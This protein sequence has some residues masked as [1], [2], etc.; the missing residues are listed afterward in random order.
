[1]I[2][3]IE[4][5]SKMKI[6]RAERKTE[7]RTSDTREKGIS[8]LILVIFSA[9]LVA[10]C[11]MSS[12]LYR[13]NPWIDANS[14][15][16]AAKKMADGQVM[17]RD[18]FD[19]KGPILY[20]LH[21]FAVRLFSNPAV[22][23]YFIETAGCIGLGAAFDRILAL[24]EIRRP[25]HRVFYTIMLL[26]VTYT[27]NTFLTGDTTEEL[28]L[29]FL[30]YGLYC[31][32]KTVHDDKPLS[33]RRGILIGCCCGWIFWMK[34]TLLGF[35]VCFALYYVFHCLYRKQ[36]RELG[37]CVLSVL[38]GFLAVTAVVFPYF[39]IHRALSDLLEVYFYDNIFFYS[40]SSN[41][42]AVSD[43]IDLIEDYV[44]HAAVS[45]LLTVVGLVYFA[46]RKEKFAVL[47]TTL[48][49]ACILLLSGHN[50]LYYMHPL[51]MFAVLGIVPL[52]RMDKKHLYPAILAVVAMIFTIGRANTN[53]KE[54][55]SWIYKFEPWIARKDQP[56][57]L[58]YHCMEDEFYTAYNIV[59]EEK[60]YTLLNLPVPEM[61][62]EQDR[63]VAEKR[64]DFIITAKDMSID[65]Y[66]QVAMT[67][68][69][70]ELNYYLYS[71]IQ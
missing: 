41:A 52:S 23:L 50:W 47:F 6:S 53:L 68:D 64:S 30:C 15:L 14:Y 25:L 45:V 21:Y 57:L 36:Y 18:I 29:P 8:I 19:H 71:R 58:L 28:C 63:Y 27:S 35:Y 5:H 43:I 51:H 4:K 3:R 59:P 69:N 61:E 40:K 39:L 22:G 54:D 20:Y 13:V 31:L 48:G 33:I 17:Y 34:Y 60:Y 65:G 42:F 67:T 46:K 9:I 26:A 24:Y 49:T 55:D 66:E 56:T 12:P 62:E 37:H 44:A 11:S 32:L 38:G 16:V 2:E 1:M 10:V 7:D 70:E